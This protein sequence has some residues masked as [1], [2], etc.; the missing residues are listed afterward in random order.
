MVRAGAC[1][2][3]DI[4]VRVYL[5]SFLESTLNA[6]FRNPNFTSI[7]EGPFSLYWEPASDRSDHQRGRIVRK[8]QANGKS[9]CEA[10]GKIFLALR[11]LSGTM[12]HRSVRG[13]VDAASLEIGG[14][15]D[16]GRIAKDRW[17]CDYGDGKRP[18]HF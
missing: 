12:P 6:F 1:V 5:F 16:V 7:P 9:F 13:G 10:F 17:R 2:D 8:V 15:G 14:L 4:K 11:E 18:R 3:Y